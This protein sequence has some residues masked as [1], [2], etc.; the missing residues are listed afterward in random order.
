[1]T[2]KVVSFPALPHISLGLISAQCIEPF[3]VFPFAIDEFQIVANPPYGSFMHSPNGLRMRRWFAHECFILVYITVAQLFGSSHWLYDY[4]MPSS[5]SVPVCQSSHT[6]SVPLNWLLL[7]FLTHFKKITSRNP[8]ISP[9]H[10]TPPV[11][12]SFQFHPAS[13][14][15]QVIFVLLKHSH[16]EIVDKEKRKTVGITKNENGNIIIEK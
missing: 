12:F 13:L 16:K 15:W 6:L 2:I 7:H 5:Y 1:M 8:D 4:R 14:A 3:K 9:S 10:C 11:S